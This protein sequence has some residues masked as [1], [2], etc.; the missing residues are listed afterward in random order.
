[1]PL[2]T[3]QSVSKYYGAQVVLSQVS[4]G[5]DAGRHTGL[6]G[7]NGA[8]KTTLLKLLTGELA[9]DE[10][11]LARQAGTRIG[12]LTQDPNL[13]SEATVIDEALSAL[14]GIRE[15]EERLRD[16][17]HALEAPQGDA[18]SAE[19]L[20]VRYGQLQE[21]YERAGGYAYHHK[22][23]AVLFGL[24]FSE[25]DL[26]QVVNVLSG[27]Q[28]TRLGLA[29]LLLGEA[30]VLLLDEPESHLDMA[31]TEWLEKYIREYPGAVVLVS[32]DRYFLD[33]TVNEMIELE[34][35]SLVHYPG[36][37]SRYLEIKAERVKAQTREYNEQREM[38]SRTEEFIR[39]NLAGQKTKQAQ[40]RRSQ[41]ERLERI[42]SPQQA[43]RAVG[44]AF[45]TMK[46]SGDDVL[47]FNDVAKGYGRRILFTGLSFL[48]RRS[49]RIGVI[50]PNGCGKSTLLRMILNEESPD[51]GEVRVGASVQIGYYDQERVSL[52][53]DRNVLNELWSVKPDLT[54]ER[55]RTV[56]G[57][58]LFAGDDA[59]KLVGNLSGGEQA[60]LALAKRMMEA[61]NFLILD[62]PTNHLDIL[63]RH[64]LERA[65]EDYPGTLLVVSH[66]RYFLD[67]VV[68]QL[69]VF[70]PDG[71]SRWEG[72]YT[73][74]RAYKEAKESLPSP[75]TTTAAPEP[76]PLP[77]VKTA[78]T[79]P[80]PSDAQ[81]GDRKRHQKTAQALEASIHAKEAE[82][83]RLEA[84]LNE[85][86]IFTDPIKVAET[87]KAYNQAKAE[88]EQLYRDW[89]VIS[90]T[91]EQL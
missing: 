88:L 85:E 62:E 33:R 80:R 90:M 68:D 41:L 64:A 10:G 71:V 79:K 91:L 37:Y 52:V 76:K 5:I 42:E 47:L 43:R 66:D 38:I 19:R 39:R 23:E 54:E 24:G 44:L 11:V 14:S 7:P 34:R 21:E 17:E 48:L 2:I 27:G 28:K 40:G 1:M 70:E 58:F 16:L 26:G 56:L 55:V 78:K 6:I 67:R 61:P 84:A 63:S 49:E 87:G 31:A 69:L 9:P 32:H 3:L 12:Y 36:N 35:R 86:A 20:L 82:I 83:V 57:R 29:K 89:E 15:L 8:G 59:F 45:H 50:G 81:T 74:Y 4:W 65:L 53:D 13:N 73:S 18:E 22:A 75:P 30:D 72:D 25:R 77:V 51:S 60:R 46:R